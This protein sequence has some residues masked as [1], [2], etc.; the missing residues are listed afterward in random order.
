MAYP[1]KYVSPM[2]STVHLVHCRSGSLLSFYKQGNY[3]ARCLS[4]WKAMVGLPQ[5]QPSTA[6]VVTKQAENRF[7]EEHYHV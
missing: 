4:L 2:S 6:L 5:A 7:Y 1:P 3:Q